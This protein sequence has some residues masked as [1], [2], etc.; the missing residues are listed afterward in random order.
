M[1]ASARSAIKRCVA[2]GI[3]L[4]SVPSRYHDGTERQATGPEGAPNA[5]SVNGRRATAMTWAV[6]RSTSPA[7]AVRNFSWSMYRSTTSE[8]S[9]FL[10]G[11][12][13]WGRENPTFLVAPRPITSEGARVR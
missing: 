10:C 9:A 2:G 5:V 6:S 12:G 1:D 11:T 4:S 3:A 8:P 13:C 7:K